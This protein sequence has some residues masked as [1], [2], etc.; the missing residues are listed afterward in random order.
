MTCRKKRNW[1]SKH[2]AKIP[3]RLEGGIA[4]SKVIQIPDMRNVVH[5]L[6]ILM[7]DD[8]WECH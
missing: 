1:D 3:R 8:S 6:S 2:L 4:S 5:N 7:R